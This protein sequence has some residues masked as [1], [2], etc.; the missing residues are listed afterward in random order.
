[1]N[2]YKYGVRLLSRLFVGLVILAT[3]TGGFAQTFFS[4]LRLTDYKTF[5]IPTANNFFNPLAPT[6]PV[7]DGLAGFW[8]FDEADGTIVYDGSGYGQQGTLLA[9]EQRVVGESGNALKFSGNRNF[10]RLPGISFGNSDYTAAAWV[11]TTTTKAYLIGNG[12]NSD[13]RIFGGKAFFG[14]YTNSGARFNNLQG[15][16]AVND[17]QWHFIVG[18]RKGNS[19]QIFVDGSLDNS[20]SISGEANVGYQTLAIRHGGSNKDYYN[21]LLDEVYVFNRAITAEEVR[22]LYLGN[23]GDTLPPTV[24]VTSPTSGA[25]VSGSTV[26]S[27]TASD[28]V[29]I[30]GVQFKL[31]GVNFGSEVTNSPYGVSWNTAQFPNGVYTLSAVAR[32][33]SGNTAQSAVVSLTVS[34]NSTPTPTP[35]PVATPTATPTPVA[36]P[37]PAPTVTPTPVTTP[38]P[39]PTNCSGVNCLSVDG[40]QTFQTMTGWEATDFAAEE[41]S[42]AWN[43]YKNSLFDSAVNDLGINRMR[44]EI[45]SGAENPVD[46]YAQWRSGQITESQY[47]ARRYEIINDNGDPNTINP[48]GFKWSQID[49][50]IE[51]IILPIRQRLQAR[52]EQ[53][54]VNVNYIDFGSSVF[55]HKTSP[56]E[57][58]EFVLATYQHIQSKYSFTPDS[59]EVIL[60]PDTGTA[61]WS[62]SQVA[63]AVKAAGDRLKA[64]GFTPRFVVGSTTNGA[65]AP[66][67]FNA[68]V[69]TPG[70]LQYVE[71]IAYHRYCCVNSTVAQQIAALGQQYGKKTAMLEWI[72]ADYKS[73][74]EDLKFGNNSSWQQFT[75][76]TLSVW[77]GDDGSAYY[78]V[79]D[80]NTTNPSI[81]LGSRTK[82]LRQYFKYVRSGAVRLGATSPNST[83][84]PLAFSN[85][86]GKHVVVVKASGGGTFSVKG[87]PAGTYG[88]F[89]TTNNAYD[90]QGADQTISNGQTLSATIP[91]SG[92]I[93]I[94]AKTGGGSPPP[95]PTP[96]ITP[97]PTPTPTPVPAPSGNALYAAA[98]GSPNGSGSLANPWDL[99]TALNQSAAATQGK[100]LYLRG[101]T[102]RGKF[103]SNLVNTVVRS[104]PGEWAK[105]DGNYT[106]TTASAVGAATAYSNSTISFSGA[107]RFIPGNTVM[108][109]TEAMQINSVN[110]DGSYQATRGWNGTSASAHGT[111]AGARLLGNTFEVNG[112][113]STYRDFEVFDSNPARSYVTTGYAGY[114]R[115]GEGFMVFGD[116]LKFI[117][118]VVHD[119][120]DGFFLTEG[121]D[122]TEVYGSIVYNNGHVAS[123]RPHGHGLYIQNNTGRKTV[124]DVISFNNFGLGMNAYG[125]NQGHANGIN[126]DGITSFNNGSPGYFPNNPTQ[127]SN[128]TNRRFSNMDIGSDVFPSNDASVTN[129]YLYHQPGSVVEIPGLTLGRSPSG[130]NTNAVVKDNYIAEPGDL[131]NVDRWSNLQ[132][133]GNTFYLF[134]N[135]YG[136]TA[137]VNGTNSGTV[138]DNNK[139]YAP[140][141]QLSCFGGSKRAPFYGY[142]TQ[143]S[144]GSTMDFNE[145]KQATGFDANSTFTPARPTGKQ[146]FVRPNRY[147]IGRANVTIFNWDKSANVALDLAN[148]GLQPGQR[149]E[150]RSVQDFF[151]A[152]VLSSQTYTVGMILNLP[153]NNL[154]VAAPIGLLY[155]PASTC[156]EF[157]VFEILPLN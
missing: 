100:T 37:T 137:K 23:T 140:S 109:E 114:V 41:F 47:N 90:Q 103:I 30:I 59:W 68:V 43:N 53:L 119:N 124:T 117:N 11:K 63:Q 76:A 31:D 101:G 8:N 136:T 4:E 18:I 92:V 42:P 149:F 7:I 146:I 134:E 33:A 56:A 153:M 97:T 80:G 62:A 142:G 48:N 26:I 21:G 130:G 86:D 29:G 106:T 147:Q 66:T 152:P 105:I 83:F 51:K 115:G 141:A 19:M 135:S 72:G 122:N 64:N 38:T 139:Y 143:G 46:Y 36:T 81:N 91:D 110:A 131:L 129:S 39:A 85:A 99:Q 155:T 118:L 73:L 16:R 50:N 78:V 77:N 123:D 121:A 2:K 71:E 138:W 95:T 82:F 5:L 156:P 127:Y 3:A 132:V 6:S 79:N 96:V 14:I 157:C 69:Q 113:D 120:A 55:E 65:S 108:V 67:Y 24:A 22:L 133:T 94:Y 12:D 107:V 112:N 104:Y 128:A 148:A 87:L 70:A 116:N 15:S 98:N 54:Y 45:K 61:N 34:N 28:N 150:V 84:D 111:G 20:I 40:S 102:Y 52:G 27:A 49:N 1:M 144:C 10:V 75:L 58:A 126:F 89:Y 57:Y 93:T 25:T 125:A 13:L 154:S 145:W 9:N 60:E 44:L 88:V 17:N 35:T 151:G 32:D 74:H